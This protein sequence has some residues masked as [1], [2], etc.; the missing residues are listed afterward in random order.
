MVINPSQSA[1][2]T[3][4]DAPNH[5]E[6][7]CRRHGLRMTRQRAGLSR[8]LWTGKNRHVS[9]EHLYHAAHH[10]GLRLSMA[11]VYNTLNQWA[12]IGLL[13]RVALD[14][15]AVY[16]DTNVSNHHHFYDEAEGRLIDVSEHKVKL[17]SLPAPPKGM[18]I[19]SVDVMIRLKSAKN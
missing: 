15:G 1:K 3:Q 6:E 5:I 17:A 16:F 8:L 10:A 14:G 19:A 12:S 13:R 7:A 9:A 11:T 2:N 4:K 18:Q